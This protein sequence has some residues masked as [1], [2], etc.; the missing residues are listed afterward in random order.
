MSSCFTYCTVVLTHTF[1]TR[2]IYFQK[3]LFI[4]LLVNL[5]LASF[6]TILLP[7]RVEYI[8]S[9]IFFPPEMCF[10]R[11]DTSKCDANRSWLRVVHC[12]YPFFL[13]EVYLPEGD[14]TWAGLLEA[15]ISPKTCD[16]VVLYQPV[17][18][19]HSRG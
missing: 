6:R 18:A 15:Q 19:S 8:S 3:L 1:G 2:R 14:K 17:P 9:K 5:K 12:T 13:L 16:K 10:G 7:L 4:G 11:W